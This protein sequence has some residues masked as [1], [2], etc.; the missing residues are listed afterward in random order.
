MNHC[1]SVRSQ[2]TSIRRAVRSFVRIYGIEHGKQPMMVVSPK[3][4]ASLQPIQQQQ[5]HE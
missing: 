1:I 4:F 5:K 3:C 2:H